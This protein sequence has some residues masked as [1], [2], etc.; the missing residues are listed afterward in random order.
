MEKIGARSLFRFWAILGLVALVVI[1]F[2]PW[3]FQ[4]NDDEL[5]M[6]LVSGAYTGTPESYAVFI[7]PLLS[8]I[9]SKLYTVFPE[10]RWY[11]LTWF[12]VMYLGYF[13]LLKVLFQSK[14][15]SLSNMVLATILLCLVIHFTLFMQFTI[16]SGF[17]ALAGFSLIISFIRRQKS[18]L[19]LLIFILLSIS[20]L[21]RWESFV[22]VGLGF[23]GYLIFLNSRILRARIFFLFSILLLFLTG[24]FSKTILENSSS[25][26]SFVSYNQARAAVSDHPVT[27]RY[28][29]E[30]KISMDSKWFYFSHWMMD[31]DQISIAELEERRKKLNSELFT[32][33]QI[34][35]SFLRSYQV[36]RTEVFKSVF[37]II[38]I[39]YFFLSG[40]D[41]KKK[42]FFFSCWATFFLVFNHFFVLNGRVI[43]LFIFPFLMALIA[44]RFNLRSKFYIPIIIFLFGL[45]GVH[46]W[47]FQE[48]ARGREVMRDEFLSL[49]SDIPINS[50]VIL[51]GYKE[52]Y[53]GIHYSQKNPV[54]FISFGWIS[55]SPFQKKALARLGL[56]SI[57]GAQDFYFFGVNINEEFFFEDYMNFKST[58]KYILMEEIKSNNWFRLYFEKSLP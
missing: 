24:F 12:S 58:E 42:V 39:I 1:W 17:A 53:L 4:T 44:S 10:V 6:W 15:Q 3:R 26:S 35:S 27:F 25:Y 45:T 8:W 52:N 51:E 32:L 36:A 29:T 34:K 19:L 18:S 9:F 49:Q 21:I 47:N 16:V 11:P 28:L 37:S 13:G 22:L 7:H 2:L 54:P 38:I 50:L 43:I 55:K 57:L 14:S 56:S 23:F 31:D 41:I 40:Y 48:E 46:L 30:N 5:M 20:I 33:P